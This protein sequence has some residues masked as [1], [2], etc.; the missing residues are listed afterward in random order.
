MTSYNDPRRSASSS[1]GCAVTPRRARDQLYQIPGRGAARAPAA[2][3]GNARALQARARAS[4]RCSH[5][6]AGFVPHTAHAHHTRTILGLSQ[7]RHTHTHDKRA[8]LCQHAARLH[9]CAVH[10][11][12]A[13]HVQ[14]YTNAVAPQLAVQRAI[15]RR[16]QARSDS[17]PFRAH[18]TS[19]VSVAPAR[20]EYDPRTATGNELAAPPRP[21]RPSRG[22]YSRGGHGL[23]AETPPFRMRS[24]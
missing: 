1:T 22:G 9:A 16:T 24:G 3:A 11:H 23:T 21:S 19:S 10:G 14:A 17:A 6:R 15:V 20:S 2:H 5:T 18:V 12:A 4:A 13:L 8:V 7:K